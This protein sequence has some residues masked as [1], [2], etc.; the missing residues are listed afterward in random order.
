LALSKFGYRPGDADG[1]LGNGTKRE[2]EKFRVDVAL[3]A[4]DQ[5]NEPLLSA[6]GVL[7]LENYPNATILVVDRRA[8]ELN[9]T[10]GAMNKAE[11]LDYLPELHKM[12]KRKIDLAFSRPKSIVF[13]IY[14]TLP[15]GTKIKT[16][17]SNILNGTRNS[18]SQSYDYVVQGDTKTG[19]MIIVN[20]FET[21]NPMYLYH[22]L[23][24]GDKL[25]ARRLTRAS[26]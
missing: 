4:G 9:E 14:Q 2:I 7:D 24:D 13:I 20:E 6:L 16:F 8:G 17:A 25:I 10:L 11:I 21:G 5:I 1:N 23:F 12:D 22:E 18:W 26:R 3:P 15:K 19:P